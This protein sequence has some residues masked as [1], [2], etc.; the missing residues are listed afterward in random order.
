M[1][2]QSALVIFALFSSASAVKLHPKDHQYFAAGLTETEV[3][4]MQMQAQLPECNGTNGTPG[5]DCTPASLSQKNTAQPPCDGNNCWDCHAAATPPAVTPVGDCHAPT[6]AQKGTAQPP[7]DG[8]NC[9][10]CHAAATPPAVTPVGDCHA[11]TYAQKGAS[12]PPCDGNN[13][14]DCHAAATPP[15]V[16]PVGDCHAPS[17][18]QAPNCDRFLTANCQPQCGLDE[19]RGCTV[20]RSFHGPVPDQYDGYQTFK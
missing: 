11:P 17:Y 16:T 1:F 10:D 18:A 3:Q 9:W 6:Y 14:W 13:C 4:G 20:P 2:K 12:Q 5:K 8:N 15:A 19:T 7:C